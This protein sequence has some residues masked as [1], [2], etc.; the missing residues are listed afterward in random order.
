MAAMSVS[1]EDA[2]LASQCLDLC[3]TLAGKSLTFSFSLTIGSSFSFSMDTRG[4][5]VLVPHRKKKTPS[6]LRRDARRREELLKKKL[7][8]STV[9]SSQSEQASAKE[10]E[11]PRKAPPVVHHHP[12]PPASSERRQVTVVGR[13][14][15]LPSFT[16]LDGEED[17]SLLCAA[18]KEENIIAMEETWFDDPPFSELYKVPPAKVRHP[19]PDFG[20]GTYV[21]TNSDSGNFLYEFQ[22]GHW[23]EV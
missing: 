18:E 13:E 5:E 4:K 21:R 15:V 8:T 12:S 16:Q 1:E 17:L 20:I 2:K 7:N 6:T 22:N 10:V 9:I 23:V 19:D 3:Q 14:K 11:V